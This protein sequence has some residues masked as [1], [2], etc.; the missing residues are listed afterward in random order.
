MGTALSYYPFPEKSISEA[1]TAQPPHAMRIS[2]FSEPARNNEKSASCEA[3][4]LITST[5]ARESILD[6]IETKCAIGENEGLLGEV[7]DEGDKL[8]AR[9]DRYGKAKAVTVEFVG[10]LHSVGEDA[11]AYKLFGCGDFLTFQHY[12]TIG[13]LHLTRANFCKTHLLCVFCSIRR[14][15]KAVRL[16]KEKFEAITAAHGQKCLEMITF[17]VKN[18]EDLRTTYSHLRHSYKLLN[19]RRRNTLRGRASSEWA[20]VQGLVGALEVTNRGRGWHP[21]FHCIAISENGINEAALRAE[22]K[23]ITGDSDQVKVVRM[24]A[25]GDHVKDFCEVFKY[26]LDFTEMSPEHILEASKVFKGKKLIFSQGLF[27]GVKIPLS[28]TDPELADLPFI[29]TVWEYF[30]E[31]GYNLK[32][33]RAIE[34]KEKKE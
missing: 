4:P 12:W 21:H 31:A 9:L 1:S 28:L 27:R 13:K 17:T 3:E 14:G 10:F 2:S 16:Y 11:L 15:A 26:S 25:H 19:Q 24:D 29:E 32:R 18:G 8:Q 23:D 20:K 5:R 22:W 30:H 6:T 34:G 7:K 33:S